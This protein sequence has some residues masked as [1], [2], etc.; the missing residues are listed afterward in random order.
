MLMLTFLSF[1][2]TPEA[3]SRVHWTMVS[4]DNF[5][6]DAAAKKMGESEIHKLFFRSPLHLGTML[7]C[8]SSTRL[9]ILE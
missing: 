6:V 7:Q 1:T 3:A 5:R 8:L 9:R 2:I 4:V